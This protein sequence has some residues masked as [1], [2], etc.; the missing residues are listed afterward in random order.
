MKLT[1]KE[2]DISGSSPLNLKK[3]HFTENQVGLGVKPN[4]LSFW[5]N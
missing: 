4:Y 3:L 2:I 1:V 5:N